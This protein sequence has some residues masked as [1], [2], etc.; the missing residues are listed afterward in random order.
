MNLFS[1]Q[2]LLAVCTLLLGAL[3]LCS[4]ADVRKGGAPA[5]KTPP[6][7]TGTA[8]QS[9]DDFRLVVERNIFNPNRVGRTKAAPEE[10]LV[11]VDA[12]SLVGTVQHGTEAIAIFNSTDPAYRKDLRAGESLGEFKLQTISADGVELMREDKPLSLKVAQQLRRVEGKDWTVSAAPVSQFDS[13]S[14][15]S[16][17]GSA[18]RGAT[19]AAPVVEI[20]A[21]A[22]E[23]LKRMMKKRE[24]QL[25]K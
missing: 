24:Q 6:V 10:K 12:V 14:S 4:A 19:A 25:K 18:S 20:P 11:R 8:G 3:A 5:P 13:R 9:Y 17:S 2:H 21:D 16:S 7:A 1:K 23:V 15:G 22:S